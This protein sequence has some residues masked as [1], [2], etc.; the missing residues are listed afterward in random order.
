VL[1]DSAHVVYK[2]NEFYLPELER[3]VLWNDP[4][5]KIAWQNAGE[6]LLSEKDKKGKLLKDAEVFV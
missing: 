1:S 2:A 4:D 5:L 6:P 3:T